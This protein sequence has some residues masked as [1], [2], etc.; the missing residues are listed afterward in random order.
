MSKAGARFSSLIAFELTRA[1]SEAIAMC[2]VN[3]MIA[4]C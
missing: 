1:A 2:D 3:L 4:G